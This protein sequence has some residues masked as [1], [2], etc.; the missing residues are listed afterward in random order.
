MSAPK[1]PSIN[2]LSFNS[3]I[4]IESSIKSNVIFLILLNLVYNLDVVILYFLPNV[5]WL[6]FPHWLLL[7]VNINKILTL[8][9][10]Q[11]IV[12]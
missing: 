2:C 11:S 1:N 9:I 10:L 8:S 7:Q 6:V 4:F 3:V 5:P 12:P